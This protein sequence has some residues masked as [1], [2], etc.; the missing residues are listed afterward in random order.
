MLDLAGSLCLIHD[1]P[2]L[3]QRALIQLLRY[4]IGSEEEDDRNDTLKHTCS[5][6]N[7]VLLFRD[8]VFQNED[9]DRLGPVHNETGTEQVLDLK[10]SFHQVSDIHDQQDHEG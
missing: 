7:T 6:R 2:P 8:T 5:S 10:T 9:I 3:N 4:R 1:A